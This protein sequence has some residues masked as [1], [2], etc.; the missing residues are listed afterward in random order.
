[1]I[2]CVACTGL[3]AFPQKAPTLHN[4]VFMGQGISELVSVSA[5]GSNVAFRAV[6][7]T[8]GALLREVQELQVGSM[9][10][11]IVRFQ[12]TYIYCLFVCRCSLTTSYI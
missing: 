10:K 3:T 1:M 9:N 6:H 4:T 8:A 12:L 5:E 11:I 7:D 2:C